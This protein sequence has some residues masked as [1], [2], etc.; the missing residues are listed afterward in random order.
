M[1]E[2]WPEHKRNYPIGTLSAFHA[3]ETVL[4]KTDK[5]F[6]EAFLH[7]ENIP[8]AL[9]IAG[10]A[11]VLSE[12]LAI[13]G[14]RRATPYGL[15][16]AKHFASIAA[17]LGIT[18]ISG[19]AL[20]CD[21]ASHQAALDTHGKTLA[22]LGGGINEYYPKKNKRL[23]QEI[24]DSGGALV[25]EWP[26]DTP[27][28]PFMFRARNRLIAS[29]ARAT[30]IVEAGLPSGTFSTADEALHANREVLVVPGSITSKFSVG[31]NTLLYQG[32][33]PV[34]NDETFID[35]L[36]R[37][38]GTLYEKSGDKSRAQKSVKWKHLMPDIKKNSAEE[39]L[40]EAVLASPMTLEELNT[41]A[42][43]LKKTQSA[44]GWLNMLLTKADKAGVIARYPD[45]TWG[46]TI[47]Q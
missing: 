42:A 27:P 38:F 31:T 21:S 45:G 33:T 28:L 10:N 30:L 7:I 20:G 6:P 1:Q 13:I 25:S 3:Q 19:G 16:L 24:I 9:Y 34:I 22:F 39:A 12:G 43:K 8:D 37:I 35:S 2:L 29:L 36:T 18:I 46:A 5:N 32:A 23:F 17:G 26:W 4:K 47:T 40:I 15:S 14:A 44:W 41:F 11:S